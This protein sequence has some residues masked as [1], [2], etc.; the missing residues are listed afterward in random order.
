MMDKKIYSS[1][2]II[3]LIV[4]L[5]SFDRSSD[6]SHSFSLGVLFP[7]PVLLSFLFFS[8]TLLCNGSEQVEVLAQ[9]HWLSSVF[10][11]EAHFLRYIFFFSVAGKKVPSSFLLYF[12]SLVFPHTLK[13]LFTFSP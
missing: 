3:I 10:W 12:F 9:D 2:I 4:L 7:W 1:I 5:L 6:K 13:R 11:M 8:Q